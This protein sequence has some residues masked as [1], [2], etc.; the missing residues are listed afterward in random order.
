MA[1]ASAG[2]EAAF[3]HP[4]LPAL[5]IVFIVALVGNSFLIACNAGRRN[6]LD[7]LPACLLGLSAALFTSVAFGGLI[8]LFIRSLDQKYAAK[9]PP[10]GDEHSPRDPSA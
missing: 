3:G 1:G 8:W 10:P 7:W 2:R 6:G 5:L 4:L 9:L